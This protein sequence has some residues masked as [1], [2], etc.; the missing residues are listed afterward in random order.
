MNHIHVCLVSD[1]TIPNIL[2]IFH[3]NPDELLFITTESMEKKEKVSSILKTLSRLGRRYDEHSEKI[4]VQEDSILDCHRKIDKWIEGKE[5]AE[6]IVNLT[7][8]TKIMSIAAYEY[9]KDYS[10]KMIYIPIPKNEFIAPFPK[11]IPGSSISLDLRLSVVQYLTAYGLE[12]VNEAK[13]SRYHN[14]ASQRKELSAWLV[15]HYIRIKNLLVWL[16]G[17]LRDHRDNKEYY[18]EGQ[19]SGAT[20]L[21]I[22][23]MKKLGFSRKGDNISIKLDRSN[24]RYLTGGWLE[25]YC[26]NELAELKGKGIDDVVLNLKLRKGGN[27][28]DVM[29]TKDNALY[30]VECKSLDQEKDKETDILYKIGALQ[31]EFGLRIESFLVSTS[32]HILKDGEI[33]FSLQS[34]AEQFKTKIVLPQEVVNFK[35]YLIQNLEAKKGTFLTK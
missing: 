6:F 1:Q 28:F 3:F 7:C 23:L 24:L 34:R 20:E 10:S 27:E 21:E 4:N 2:G 11:K 29:F 32:P 13:L 15:K 19:F 18:L 14:E 31:K 16:S 22:E 12:I 26:F 25:E 9:F 5:D 35:S 30:F 17:N 33:K 8:G